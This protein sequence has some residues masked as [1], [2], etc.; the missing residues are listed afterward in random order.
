LH[1]SALTNQTLKF[2]PR[3]VALLD[4]TG[5]TPKASYINA[6]LRVAFD[7]GQSLHDLFNNKWMR[8]R[9]WGF[10]V[11]EHNDD[12]NILVPP[13]F[14]PAPKGPL[15]CG[16]IARYKEVTV[17]WNNVTGSIDSIVSMNGRLVPVELKS[18][19][20]D[21][22]KT[23]EAPLAEHRIR[24]NLYLFLF[25]AMELDHIDTD[26][27]KVLYISKGYGAKDDAGKITPFKEFDVAYNHNT[28]TDYLKKAGEVTFWRSS[29]SMPQPICSNSMAPRVKQCSCAVECFS[30]KYPPAKVES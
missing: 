12:P 15:P 25:K 3:E 14:G 21:Q 13:A 4:V 24:S 10:W 22:F 19:D 1:A 18:M 30:G 27:M 23:L 5:K 20:K 26:V 28:I 29:K 11:C 9:A 7:Q 16:C 17:Q 6:P 2:C 8:H